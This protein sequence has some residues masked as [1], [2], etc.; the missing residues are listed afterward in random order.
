VTRTTCTPFNNGTTRFPFGSTNATCSAHDAAGNN[1]S[2]SFVVSVLDLEYPVVSCPPSVSLA[3]PFGLTANVTVNLT[4]PNATDN[5]G[6]L[7]RNLSVSRFGLTTSLSPTDRSY[8][9]ATVPSSVTFTFRATDL[10]YETTPC[11]WAVTVFPAGQAPDIVPPVVSN[12]PTPFMFYNSPSSSYD[13][14][15]YNSSVAVIT[16]NTLPGQR[17]GLVSWPVLNATD[18]RGDV[19]A[20]YLDWSPNAVGASTAGL[21]AGTY[22]VAYQATDLSGNLAFCVFKVDVKDVEPPVWANCPSNTSYVTNNNPGVV[23]SWPTRGIFATDNFNIPHPYGTCVSR[24]AGLCPV[25]GTPLST[26]LMLPAAGSGVAAYSFVYT[27]VDSYSNVAKPCV[28]GFTITDNYPPTL[29]GCSTN[30]ILATTAPGKN[31]A[32][33]SNLCPVI[34]ATDNVGVAGVVYTSTPAGYNC[35]TAIP[36]TTD[37]GVLITV[38]AFDEAGLSSFCSLIVTVSDK[39]PP[40]LL[41]CNPNADTIITANCDPGLPTATINFPTITATDNSGTVTLEYVSLPAGLGNG[42]AF[43]LGASTVTVTAT[44][45]SFNSES[46]TLRVFVADTQPPVIRGFPSSTST[47]YT[48]RKNTDLNSAFATVVLPN[49]TVTDNVALGSYGYQPSTYASNQPFPFPVGQ[50]QVVYTAAD[51]S[52]NLASVTLVFGVVD[53]Q[54]PVISGCVSAGSTIS[55]LFANTSFGLPNFPVVWPAV[56]ASDNVDGPRVAMSL[57]SQPSGFTVGSLFRVG[58]TLM[59]YTAVDTAGNPSTCTFLIE[60]DD[61]EPPHLI[62]PSDVSD[63]LPSGTSLF[64]VDWRDPVITDNYVVSNVNFTHSPGTNFSLGTTNVTYGAVDASGNYASC[65]FRITLSE[66]ALIVTQSSSSSSIGAVGAGAGGGGVFLL[67]IIAVVV[68]VVLRRN[69]K[70]KLQAA[71]SGYA[72]LMAMSDEFILERARAI[73]Q[74]LLDQRGAEP[75]ESVTANIIHPDR[76]FAPPPTTLAELEE[77]MRS[78]VNKEIPRESLQF[79]PEL[80]S[81]EFGAVYEGTYKDHWKEN[82]DDSD[83]QKVAIKMLRK[84]TS[85]EDKVRFL[86]EA[87]IMA[88]FNHPN[89]VGLTGVCTQ[90]S[91]EPTLIVLP[92]MHLG[93]LQ[94]YLQNPMVKDQLETLTMVRMALDVARGMQYLAEAGFVHRDL[95]ARNVLLDNNM[96]CHVGDFGLSV[97]LASGDDGEDGVYSGSED[98]KI[99]IRWTS[100]EAFC[101]HQFS[102]ASD[103]WSFGV[104]LWELW[105]YAELPY[106]GWNNKKVTEQVSAGFRLAK[107]GSCPDEVYKVMIECWN[108]NIKRR[109]TF[110]KINAALVEAWKDIAREALGGD[111]GNDNLYDAG[112]DGPTGAN[113]SDSRKGGTALYDTGD[114]GDGPALKA[115]GASGGSAIYDTGD[116]DP[117]PV[118][119]AAKTGAR[120]GAASQIY[121]TGDDFVVPTAALKAQGDDVFGLDDSFEAPVVA[122]GT[123]TTT[124]TAGASPVLGRP[125]STAGVRLLL[126]EETLQ[127]LGS[128]HVGLRVAVEKFGDGTLRFFGP[129]HRDGKPRCGVELDEANGINNGTIG[130]HY[131]F[132]CTAKHGVLVD[133]RVVRLLSEQAASTGNSG[134]GYL[135]VTSD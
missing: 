45:P 13:S 37:Q 25:G 28:F 91:S 103:V 46:C 79:G 23:P 51:T 12:C 15:M 20:S 36:I 88:Q 107:P 17:Y 112:D 18:N 44:D 98:A 111:T 85:D 48:Y 69:A 52:L 125:A 50:T 38:T 115:R 117:V 124:T 95:A 75:P 131:Y 110:A 129:H 80:G 21:A 94:G 81:G 64:V 9:F 122:V 61:Y 53:N 114:D 68:L 1:A 123:A 71:A 73:Q 7:Y 2:C 65:T 59:T 16:V 11:S 49:I 6:I 5:V 42:S 92:Y 40:F 55:T 135:A 113:D 26:M 62:C 128:Q 54:P 76:K 109:I 35:S 43:P 118:K 86:K 41:G 83:S 133:P 104:L 72:E 74:T 4:S 84:A 60:V 24:P 102:S 34:T 27:A 70:K 119:A 120:P 47:S 78:T 32:D 30:L 89:I 106:K 66:A 105:S 77:Y 14:S 130:D 39:E 19:V 22:I 126:P 96:V 116:D 97:D 87:A 67:L 57:V 8:T 58:T 108:K 29:I 93:S 10:S 134:D 56:T 31:T 100:I 127:D 99:P 101:F 3:I 121:D 33:I 132:S 63:V 82:D 90:P